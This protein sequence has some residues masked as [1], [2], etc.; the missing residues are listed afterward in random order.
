MNK[1]F[2]FR[3]NTTFISLI[4]T[5][6]RYKNLIWI[7]NVGEYHA[8]SLKKDTCSRSTMCCHDRSMKGLVSET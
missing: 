8:C 1:K 4:N 2:P 5:I 7:V 3:F 6:V